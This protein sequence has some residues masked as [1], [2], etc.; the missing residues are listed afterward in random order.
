MSLKK[1]AVIMGSDSDFPVVKGALDPGLEGHIRVC[2][3]RPGSRAPFTTGKSL[4][5][6]MITATFFKDITS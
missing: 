2:P 4:S 6:P 3:S 1:V 5:E